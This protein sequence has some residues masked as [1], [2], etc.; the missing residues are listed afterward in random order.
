MGGG[1]NVEQKNLCNGLSMFTPFSV[2]WGNSAS[3]TS[4][5]AGFLR[6]VCRKESYQALNNE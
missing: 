3:F 4:E 1:P 2:E 6:V 5:L